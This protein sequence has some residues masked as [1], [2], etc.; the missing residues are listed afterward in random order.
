MDSTF[1]LTFMYSYGKLLDDEGCR[2]WLSL[3]ERLDRIALTPLY[4]IL[5]DTYCKLGDL[6][7]ALQTLEKM[8]E[9]KLNADR[10]RPDAYTYGSIMQL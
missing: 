1:F 7:S 4:N 5:I 10:L 8:K 2:Y 6:R 9:S 3:A